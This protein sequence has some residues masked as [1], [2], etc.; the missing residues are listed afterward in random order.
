MNN[1]LHRAKRS[2]L[3]Q[4]TT[5]TQTNKSQSD[6]SFSIKL[7]KRTS[8]KGK[9]E[10]YPNLSLLVRSCPVL[11]TSCTFH[12]LSASRSPLYKKEGTDDC[13]KSKHKKAH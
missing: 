4:S 10:M 12:E 6:S 5:H 2:T 9:E 3:N 1:Y 11:A 8:M 7:N 13:E